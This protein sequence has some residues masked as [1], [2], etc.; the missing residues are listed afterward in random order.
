[1]KQKGVGQSTLLS[2][3]CSR[4]QAIRWSGSSAKALMLATR[5]LSRV[6]GRIGQPAADVAVGFDEHNVGSP[7]IEPPREVNR[8][9]APV[10]PPPTIAIRIG[11]RLNV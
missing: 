8:R 5:T 7:G 11:I 6:A 4:S 9:S 10:A 2:V 1:M 3:L